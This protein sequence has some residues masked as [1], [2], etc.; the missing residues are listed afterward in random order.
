LRTPTVLDLGDDDGVTP[1]SSRG[2]EGWRSF[3]VDRIA[4]PAGT[5]ART[6]PRPLPARDA[7]AFVTD[8]MSAAPRGHEARLT[9]HAPAAAVEARA[10][11]G[12][13]RVEP[14]DD[15]TCAYRTGDDDLDWLAMRVLMLGVDFE[16]H[17]PPELAER[18]RSLAGRIDRATA[19]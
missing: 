4:A 6:E 7:A 1:T 18:L 3:R 9:L 2:R 19:P 17:E 10:P 13:G 8:S 12:W 14:L 11:A 16:V 5:G 15:A